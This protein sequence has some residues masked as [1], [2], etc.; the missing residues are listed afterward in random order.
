[1]KLSLIYSMRW[2]KGGLMI[3]PVKKMR[4]SMLLTQLQFAELLGV[5][6]MTI[7]SYE[8]GSST[9]RYKMIKKLIAM[10]LAN[11]V[12]INV[13]DFFVDKK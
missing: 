9:P 6:R 8:C 13:D 10:A 12:E 3:S 11:K 5:S 2:T 4:E 1:M 7:S